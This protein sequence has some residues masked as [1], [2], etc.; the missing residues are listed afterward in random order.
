MAYKI[1]NLALLT[2]IVVLLVKI[3]KQL[4]IDSKLNTYMVA[5]YTKM[6]LTDDEAKIILSKL[7]SEE[8]N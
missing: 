2:G 3:N 8:D 1:L 6:T 4:R 5:R 7:Y